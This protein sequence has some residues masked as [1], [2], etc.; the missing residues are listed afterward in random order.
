M[1]C[2]KPCSELCLWNGEVISDL[3]YKWKE[4]SN[5]RRREICAS[6]TTRTI[7]FLS[8]WTT[9]NP[10][11]IN[12]HNRAFEL[13]SDHLIW[14]NLWMWRWKV[15]PQGHL[16]CF[17]FSVWTHCFFVLPAHFWHVSCC[18]LTL[19]LVYIWLCAGDAAS[20]SS[21]C[22]FRDACKFPLVFPLLSWQLLSVWFMN[23]KH[24]WGVMRSINTSEFQWIGAG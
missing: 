12:N 2:P 19:M 18:L 20:L 22:L 4:V 24:S 14:S 23:C 13:L 16:L 21:S 3:F 8:V 17:T 10:F 1:G 9:V 5:S 15:N 7:T 6:L 11:Q